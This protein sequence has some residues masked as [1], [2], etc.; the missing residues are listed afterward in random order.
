MTLSLTDDLGDP[1]IIRVMVVSTDRGGIEEDHL[2]EAALFRP[3]EQSIKS[4]DDK[5]GDADAAAD[6]L[7]LKIE[8]R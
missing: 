6:L 3:R 2:D 4:W 8:V 1:N 5:S 7:S